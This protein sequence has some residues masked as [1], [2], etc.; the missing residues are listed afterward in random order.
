MN[1]AFWVIINVTGLKRQFMLYVW[2][3]NVKKQIISE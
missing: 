2:S 3:E 1:L